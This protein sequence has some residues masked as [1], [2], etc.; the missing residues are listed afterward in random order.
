MTRGALYARYSCDQK[1]VASIED[2]LRV[3][4]ERAEREGWHVVG[5]YEDAAIT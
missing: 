2:Q 1:P 3:C 5:T 4:R